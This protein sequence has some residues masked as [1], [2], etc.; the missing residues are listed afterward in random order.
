M[1]QQ[2]LP[3]IQPVIPVIPIKKLGYA[4]P[5]ECGGLTPNPNGVCMDCRIRYKKRERRH[6]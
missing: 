5:N 6:L 1:E 4:C 3:L 2:K